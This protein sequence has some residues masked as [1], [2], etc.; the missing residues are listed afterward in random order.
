MSYLFVYGTLKS[1][2]ENH[3][4]IKDLEYMGEYITNE[5]YYE[6]ENCV[7][8]EKD[9]NCNLESKEIKGELYKLPKNYI[10]LVDRFEQH[11]VLFNRELIY[12]KNDTEKELSY[13]YFKTGICK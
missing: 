1:V 3:Y 7:Y 4:I 11:P 13:I 6:K 12:V 9:D 5:K 2:N 10:F 8:K